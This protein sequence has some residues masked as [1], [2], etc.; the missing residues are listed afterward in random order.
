MGLEILK[1]GFTLALIFWLV[2]LIFEV[3]WINLELV[4]YRKSKITPERNGKQHSI[5]LNGALHTI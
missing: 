1:K 4:M 2:L 5:S 3:L